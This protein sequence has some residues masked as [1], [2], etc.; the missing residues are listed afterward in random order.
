MILFRYLFCRM[1]PTRRSGTV[2]LPEHL[3]AQ[4]ASHMSMKDWAMVCGTCKT[5][6]ALQ[7]RTINI[8]SATPPAGDTCWHRSWQGCHGQISIVCFISSSSFSFAIGSACTGVVWASKRLGGVEVLRLSPTGALGLAA[9]EV[10]YTNTLMSLKQFEIGVPTAKAT[11]TA[12]MMWFA[13]VLSRAEKLVLLSAVVGRLKWFPPLVHLKHLVLRCWRSPGKVIAALPHAKSLQTLSLHAESHSGEVI[14]LGA[15]KLGSLPD[16]RAVAL[17]GVCPDHTHLPKECDLHI[18]GLKTLDALSH[19]KESSALAYLRSLEVSKADPNFPESPVLYGDS[20]KWKNLSTVSI[21]V[22][23]WGTWNAFASL[24]N[25]AHVQRLFV[26]ADMELYVTVPAKVSWHKL[27][28]RA[29]DWME[30]KFED[31]DAFAGTVRSCAFT[32]VHLA[33]PRMFQLCLALAEHGISW[34]SRELEDGNTTLAFPDITAGDFSDCFCGACMKC[35]TAFG[36]AEACSK[37]LSEDDVTGSGEGMYD[38]SESEEG[39]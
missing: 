26:D 34:A 29:N 10:Q 33:G 36:V 35:L 32:S 9:T 20:Q 2:E 1:P 8:P 27:G 25:L 39:E 28:L 17:H 16:L 22:Y 14:F 6:F 18:A 5:T 15:L 11:K 13:W 12:F 3:W 19:G 37:V 30:V 23:K 31:M 38:E 4:I 21:H 7:P 24:A